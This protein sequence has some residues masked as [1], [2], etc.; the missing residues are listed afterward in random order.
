MNVARLNGGTTSAATSPTAPRTLSERDLLMLASVAGSKIGA[1]RLAN[2]SG[3]AMRRMNLSPSA[4]ENA[5]SAL[6]AT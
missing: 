4:A 5:S 6:C 3:T 2:A 1:A